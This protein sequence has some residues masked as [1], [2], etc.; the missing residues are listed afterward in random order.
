[1]SDPL[2]NCFCLRLPSLFLLWVLLF[3]HLWF[4]P[5]L[6]SLWCRRPAFA[7]LWC[8]H[9]QLYLW[10]L[11]LLSSLWWHLLLS[12]LWCHLLLS[13]LWCHLLLSCLSCHLLLSCLWCHL[14]LHLHLLLAWAYLCILHPCNIG[15]CLP[16]KAAS[17]PGQVWIHPHTA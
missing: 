1:M 9:L 5:L 4:L 8:R 14:H 3:C 15:V 13:C 2:G 6:S 7:C 17:P 16:C 12:S 10:F 11:L